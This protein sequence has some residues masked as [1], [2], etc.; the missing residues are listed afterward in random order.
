MTS[1]YKKAYLIL[2]MIS[3]LL[4]LAPAIYYTVKTA[5]SADLLYQKIALASS[6]FVVLVLSAVAIVNKITLK[7]RLW[8]VLITMYIVLE[9]L[10]TPIIIIGVCQVIDE[11][12]VAPWGK[13]YRE[14]WIINREIDKR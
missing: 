3:I 8:I 14:K 4:N 11:L 9:S 13:I 10:I 6:L 1:K 2:T 12:I 7:S 5:L